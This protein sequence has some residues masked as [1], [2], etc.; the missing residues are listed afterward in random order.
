MIAAHPRFRAPQTLRVPARYCSIT[1]PPSPPPAGVPPTPPADPGRLHAL[2]SARVITTA[3]A[4]AGTGADCAARGGELLLVSLTDVAST[5]HPVTLEGGRGWEFELAR[6]RFLSISDISY[7]NPGDP[8]VA[9]VGY[10]WQW[11]PT[12]LGQLLEFGG[13]ALGASATFLRDGNGWIVR[14]PGM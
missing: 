5:F 10:S 11:E 8:K 6:R 7:D 2:E 12:L 1:A 9:H 13:P 3:K 14:Q 4:P